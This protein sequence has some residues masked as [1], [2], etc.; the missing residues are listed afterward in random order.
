MFMQGFLPKMIGFALLYLGIALDG[1]DGDIARYRGVFSLRGVYLDD[2]QHLIVPPLMLFGLAYSVSK[3][4]LL[5]PDWLIVSA[6][7]GGIGWMIIKVN[8]KEPFHIMGKHFLRDPKKYNLIEGKNIDKPELAATEAPVIGKGSI[9]RRLLAIR[10]QLRQFL[11]A[12]LI[13]FSVMVIERLFVADYASF[14]VTSW[15]IVGYGVFL[16]L[17]VIEEIVKSY[18]Y[19]DGWVTNTY[20]GMILENETLKQFEEDLK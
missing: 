10:F 19:I 12:V 3:V 14:P 20:K 16:T 8:G 13:F 2:V 15:L 17:H 5:N 11:L 4:T 18:F 9:L 7:V 1:V 6:A